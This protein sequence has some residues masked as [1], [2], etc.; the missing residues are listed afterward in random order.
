MAN[1]CIAYDIRSAIAGDARV[2]AEVQVASW[3]AAYKGLMPQAVLD[4]YTVPDRTER[5]TKVLGAPSSAATKVA[6]FNN[7]SDAFVSYGPCRDEDLD[8]KT[9]GEIWALYAHPSSWSQGVGY[10]LCTRALDALR[11]KGA[12][13]ASLW[14]LKGNDRAIRFYEKVGFRPDGASQT[15]TL[16]GHQLE[17]SRYLLNF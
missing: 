14:V 11:E 10:T 16:S 4:D 13:A 15:F 5:W 17:E 2:L 7:L 6:E 12:A 8:A 1:K 3:H 9:T